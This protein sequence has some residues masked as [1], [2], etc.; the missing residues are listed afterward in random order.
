VVEKSSTLQQDSPHHSQRVFIDRGLASGEA[1]SK[2]GTLTANCSCRYFKAGI[3]QTCRQISP[4]LKARFDE[5][6][7]RHAELA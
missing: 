7:A 1:V 5:A 2:S 6:L 4:W 3:F